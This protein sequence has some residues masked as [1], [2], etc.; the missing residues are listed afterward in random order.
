VKLTRA[1]ESAYGLQ[2]YGGAPSID[3]V[4][5]VELRRHADDGGSMTE[6]GRLERGALDGVTGF[7]LAQV[8][9]SVLQPGTIK[10]FHVHRRQ[11]DVWYV[12]PEDRVLLV[13]ADVREGSATEGNRMRIVLGNGASR[14][15]VVPPGVAHGC[16]N[17][18][19]S[20]SR[21]IYFADLRFS[22]DPERCDEGRLPWDFFG[23]EIWEV[24]KE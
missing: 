5:V 11:T 17:L 3:G 19:E 15:V 24:S 20:I 8:N 7:E 16:R 12:P 14:Q 9:Y 22:P 23:Q 6:L 4:Q 18:A 2:S 13:L 1:A 21:V 10:A